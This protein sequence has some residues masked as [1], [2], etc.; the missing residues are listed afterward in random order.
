LSSALDV[1]PT[2]ASAEDDKS[3]STQDVPPSATPIA[4]SANTRTRS[5]RFRR[6]N[7]RTIQPSRWRSRAVLRHL[8]GKDGE[9]VGRLLRPCDFVD[10]RVSPTTLRRQVGSS[11]GPRV[12]RPGRCG[13][14]ARTTGRGGSRK[15]RVPTRP[16]TRSSMVTPRSS[17]P[18][19]EYLCVQNALHFRAVASPVHADAV[20]LFFAVS[21]SHRT[22]PA[23]SSR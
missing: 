18:Q 17:M 7:M 12:F 2:P 6:R 13:H 1:R 8:V 16:T 19:C 22:V 9:E 4:D 3:P 23:T 11:R 10:E 20:S 15:C 14:R 5:R 21:S